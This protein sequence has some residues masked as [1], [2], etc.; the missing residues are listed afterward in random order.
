MYRTRLVCAPPNVTRLGAASEDACATKNFRANLLQTPSHSISQILHSSFF[1]LHSLFFI[2]SFTFHV[3]FFILADSQMGR[4]YTPLPASHPL[5]PQAV[6]L[7]V[8]ELLFF[9]QPL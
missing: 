3:S 6:L 7:D 5:H 9:W 2:A 1:I 8:L 4:S